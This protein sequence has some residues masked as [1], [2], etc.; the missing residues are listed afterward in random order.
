MEIAGAFFAFGT[1]YACAD[2]MTAS[3][4]RQQR[5]M[6]LCPSAIF[7]SGAL[8]TKQSGIYFF[9]LYVLWLLWLLVRSSHSTAL[10]DRRSIAVA[11]ALLAVVA[12]PMARNHVLMDFGTT[13]NISFLITDIHQGRTPA[14]RWTWAANL[15]LNV[16][17]PALALIVRIA[18]FLVAVSLT[19]RVGAAVTLLIVVPYYTLWALLFSYELRTMATVVPFAALASGIGLE[20]MV[21]LVRRLTGSRWPAAAVALVAVAALSWNKVLLEA[22]ATPWAHSALAVLPPLAAS[23]AFAAL[24][25]KLAGS[26]LQLRAQPV[27]LMTAVVLICGV[28]RLPGVSDS[29]LIAQQHEQQMQLGSPE[30][31]RRLVEYFREHP[32]PGQVAC[33]YYYFSI[34]P[35]IMSRCHVIHFPQNFTLQDAEVTL[36]RVPNARYLMFVAAKRGPGTQAAMAKAGYT[37][38]FCHDIFCFVRRP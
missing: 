1:L 11:F 2:Y 22:A 10:A 3:L 16:R 13:S 33:E 23:V 14:Q 25:A 19:S 24:L 32:E 26:R 28:T 34:V 29:V 15:L 31:N 27:L 12:Y 30:L 8:M 38:I 18:L 36:S 21:G 37:E 5:L 7:A 35:K 9:V 6:A 4:V 17:G 20:R